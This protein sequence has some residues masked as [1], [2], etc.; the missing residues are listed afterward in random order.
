MEERKVRLLDSEALWSYAL[1]TLGGRAYSI[2]ELREKLRRRAERAGDVDDILARLKEHGYL[3]DRRFAEGYAAARLS[4][5]RFGRTR[6]LQDLRQHR[7]APNLAETTV[8]KVYEN[9]DEVAL[10]E[11]WVR[12]KYRGAEREGLFQEDKDLA[13]AY[14]RLV[15]AGFRT[16]EIVK[17]LKRFAKNPDLLDSF[18]PPE[19]E[20]EA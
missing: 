7:V 12:K 15:R 17:V 1:K 6:V 14:R 18:E 8:K 3:D 20:P 19:E 9:V 16:G 13:A 11:D 10:I 5:D 2:G 4:N